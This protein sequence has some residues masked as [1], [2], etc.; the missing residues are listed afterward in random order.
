M[1]LIVRL[2]ENPDF[3]V[4][5][6]DH[7]VS[8][9]DEFSNLSLFLERISICLRKFSG[10]VLKETMFLQSYD[11]RILGEFVFHENRKRRAYIL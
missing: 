5:L 4:P 11:S 1:I 10:L 8:A 3:D 9:L 2:I 6:P 7:T